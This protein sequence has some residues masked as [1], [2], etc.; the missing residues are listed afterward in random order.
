MTSLTDRVAD[1][2]RFHACVAFCASGAFLALVALMHAIKRDLQPD[3]HVL[4]E[5]A[6]GSNGWIMALAFLVW[7]ASSTALAASLKPHVTTR[8][9]MIGIGLLVVA[10]FGLVLA[11]FATTDPVTATGDQLTTHGKLHGV[12]AMLGIP[13]VLL[14]STLIT[15]DLRRS[16]AWRDAHHWL[17]R[18]TALAWA[19]MLT[20]AVVMATM[21]DGAYGPD[22]KVGWPNR[23]IALTY[24]AWIMAAASAARVITAGP[25]ACEPALDGA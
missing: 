1:R 23:L 19:A 5:Y 3:W 25:T 22:V 4:S 9:G 8:A 20:N 11:A 18:T 14:A 2:S 16:L 7:A 6:I 21:Y 12:G 15:W 10:A 24:S 13:A 17:T